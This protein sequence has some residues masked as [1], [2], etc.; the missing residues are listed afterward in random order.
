MKRITSLIV[1]LL[2]F[3]VSATF[4]QDIQIK[5]TVTASEDGS[6]LP[7]VY[8]KIKGT[9]TGTASDFEGNF[10]LTVP[11]NAT[12]VFS[13]IG[14]K[15]QEVALAGQS[16]LMIALE[17]D[18]TQ[19]EEVVVT[20]LGI[21]RE[22]K[23]LGY[24]T[25]E[26]SGEAV[27]TV[28]TSNFMN[29][30]SGKVAGVSIKTGGNMGGSTNILI[31]GA[32]SLTGNNQPLFVIDGVP[33][34]NSIT[35]N[36]GQT[37]GR[38]GYDYGNAASD[39]N[40]NDIESIN[41]LKGA[42]ASALYGAR[43]AN[44]VVIIITKKGGKK[45]G[46]AL[47]VSIN[48]SV[49]FSKYDPETFPEYQKQYGGGYGPFYSGG[50]HPGLEEF[51]LDGDGTDDLV[52]PF[53]EDASYGE[54]FDPSLQVYQWHSLY[55]ESEHYGQKTPW[56]AGKNGPETFFETGVTLN[57]TVDV[58]GGSDKTTFRLSYTNYDESSIMPNGRLL[59][60]TFSFN[61]S[62]KVLNNLT[63]SA[64]AQYVNT[65]GR[66]RNST[67]Y[68]DNIMSSFRQWFQTNV[69]IQE[70]ADLFHKT[71][72]NLTWNPNYYDNTRPI[73]WDN[74]Y[75]VRYK[76]YQTD[77][78]DRLIGY[79]AAE[80]KATDW[81]TITGK[82]TIDTYSEL[83]EERKAVGSVSGELGVQRPDVTS[84]YSRYQRN[85]T[86][87]NTDV[88]ANF[89][90]NLTEKFNITGLVGTSFRRVTADRVFAS[91]NGGLSVPDVYA[92]S[93]SVDPMLP[94]E[95]RLAKIAMNSYYASVSLGYNNMLFIDG[96]YRIDQSS[97]LPKD[98]WT[99]MYPSVSGS[100]LFSELVDASWLQLGKIR[101]NYAQV[102]NDAP[103]A[104][105]KDVYLPNTPFLG[106][107]MVTVPSTK[108]NAELKP[109]ETTNIEGGLELS[110]FQ[111]RLGL[112]LALYQS[113][114]TNQILPVSVSYATGYSF[115]YVNAGEIQNKGVELQL[116]GTPVKLGA[117]SWDIVL[118]WARNVNE[119]VSLEEGI[120][121]LRLASLQ[122]GLTINARVGE[123]YGVIQGQDH[124]YLD[125]RK[126]IRSNG[127][128]QKTATSDIVLG[129]VNPD[130]NGGIFNSLTYKDISFSFLI[131]IQKGGDIFSLD[132]W[133]GQGTGLYP[134]SVV[135]NDLGNP[136]RNSLS[137]A[138]PGG[139]ILDGVLADGTENTRRVAG[140]D[141]RL[142]GWATNPNSMFVYDASYVKLREVVL[143]Y[144]LPS[145]LLNKTFIS[146]AT[147]SFVGSNL[148]IISKNLPYAD[149]EASQG[150][151]NIQGWQSGVM[152]A[153]RNY[154]FS[155][156]VQF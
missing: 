71:G 77:E 2:L 129:N 93:N 29:T 14:Y 82:S 136:I 70:Q 74:P 72:R 49:T 26:V 122:G 89:R 23:S 116:R 64:S 101:L 106:N 142:L 80:W 5:G 130:W 97:T 38:S 35:N 138:N 110:L 128:Y 27:S 65:K 1:C 18:V 100:F 151:G 114:T 10:Q 125:G 96:T 137:D 62:Y 135:T 153:T 50:D 95:E 132:Q 83:Q 144:N 61:G 146:K 22:K 124:V 150:A 112:D 24:A 127:Y 91:T 19:V 133:Y 115:K 60:N 148:W 84:G 11:S 113:N 67:G 30:L 155:L 48:S 46:K 7:G 21:T 134:E 87:R 99:Y 109:E 103:W 31:R 15:E 69:D 68:S 17:Q 154:G 156:N 98:N 57:N 86:E 20:A 79:V 59:R 16:V 94:P 37:T 51:D 141:Y 123:P 119:V 118:N 145:K 56:V 149:P 117:F 120:E 25:Q 107:P 52:V 54:K 36:S 32:K 4:A 12:L 105:D 28:K 6:P 90:K 143:S 40:P 81:M 63:V 88:M 104:S 147:L 73:Y 58:T 140:D 75:W 121:V 78:R 41:I 8:V 43:A 111:N 34:D 39:I 139:V 45:E 66:G 13:S 42:A 152:P 131:D 108:N 3:G 53:Y 126:V 9:N 55:P 44:G 92:L 85:F 33:V 47:G 76:N 102:G